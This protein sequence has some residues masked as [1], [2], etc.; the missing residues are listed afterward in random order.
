MPEYTIS[1]NGVPRTVIAPADTP[2]LWVLREDLGLTGTKYGCGIGLCLSCAVHLDG[3]A[4]PS[5]LFRID[6]VGDREVVTIE[7]LSLDRSHPVQRAW[8][9]AE[10]PQC[11]WCQSGQVMVAAAL[12]AKTPRP[13]DEQIDE[14][15][16]P[17]LCRCGTYARIRDA[18][19]AAAK[20]GAR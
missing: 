10:V 8:V 9:Q 16:S 11:G 19:H 20:G 6:R 14:A 5:C 17:V 15:M 4:V 18:V 2:L 3:E 1:V 7:G 13:T 12:L